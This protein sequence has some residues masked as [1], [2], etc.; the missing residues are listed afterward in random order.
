MKTYDGIF[1]ANRNLNN[2]T[3]T[4]AWYCNGWDGSWSN[5][6]EQATAIMFV[7]VTSYN[8]IGQLYIGSNVYARSYVGESWNPWKKLNN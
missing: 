6:P 8:Y 7:F 1:N 2:A 4:G 3:T 5:A